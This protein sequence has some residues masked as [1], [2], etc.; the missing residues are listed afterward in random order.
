[1]LEVPVASLG[2]GYGHYSKNAPDIRLPPAITFTVK[3]QLHPDY[4]EK[5][6]TLVLKKSEW[7]SLSTSLAWFLENYW[8]MDKMS[9]RYWNVITGNSVSIPKSVP[10][11]N[12]F[13]GAGCPPEL[14]R[15]RF[16]RYA[17]VR[18]FF[19]GLKWAR[20]MAVNY[21]IDQ[22]FGTSN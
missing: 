16:I 21:N 11:R 5:L 1:L 19:P 6:Q 12:Y 13:L 2:F 4:F 18:C 17:K 20:S 9:S 7:S 8:N 3:E 10:Q 14:I 22:V 15:E